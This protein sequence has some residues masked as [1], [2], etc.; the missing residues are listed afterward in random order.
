MKLTSW[1]G[2]SVKQSLSRLWKKKL[3]LVPPSGFLTRS[4]ATC[5]WWRLG[6]DTSH[7]RAQDILVQI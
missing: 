3:T 1:L 5:F 7:T 6:N 2:K 4:P